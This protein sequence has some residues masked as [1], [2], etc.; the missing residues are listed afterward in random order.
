MAGQ[1]VIDRYLLT[2]DARLRG[3]ATVRRDLLAEARDGLHDAAE[4]Y[5]AA[6]LPA[7][8]A[9]RRA[10]TD[11]G[12]IGRIARDYQAELAVAHGVRFIRS[13][14][15][16]I[17]IMH[18]VWELTRVFWIGGWAS[19]PEWARTVAQAADLTSWVIAVTAAVILLA[20]R[21]LA[22]RIGD[23]RLV[24]RL[25]SAWAVGAVGVYVFTLATHLAIL[26]AVTRLGTGGFPPPV[27]VATVFSLVVT[28]RLVSQARR[29]FVLVA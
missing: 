4:S 29:C 13:L 10:V 19:G 25:A 27:L 21:V 14:L 23:T 8:E 26:V 17:P 12:P 3:P 6:G 5:R 11:F 7:G 16:V 24:G 2:L 22:R 1:G 28:A 15:L 20:W 9:E 18:V